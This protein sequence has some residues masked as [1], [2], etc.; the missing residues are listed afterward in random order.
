MQYTKEINIGVLGPNWEGPYAVIEVIRPG[1]YWLEK[2]D[3]TLVPHA[4][5]AEHLRQYYQ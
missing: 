4:W 2:L 5:N 3:H 1:T